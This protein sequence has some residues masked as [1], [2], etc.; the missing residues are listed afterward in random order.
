MFIDGIKLIVKPYT[1]GTYPGKTG[2]MCTDLGCLD[3]FRKNIKQR[4]VKTFLEIGTFDGIMI[5]VLAEE[6][7]NTIFHVIDSFAPGYNTGGGGSS[8]IFS[9]K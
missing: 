7:K 1:Y 2:A 3:W 9:C 6:N 4:N 8:G 5:S